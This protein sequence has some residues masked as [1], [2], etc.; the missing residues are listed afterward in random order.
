MEDDPAGPRGA[1]GGGVAGIVRKTSEV[2]NCSN[3]DDHSAQKLLTK[4]M[5]HQRR[6]RGPQARDP[7]GLPGRRQAA[8]H[9]ASD[10]QRRRQR[11]GQAEKGR[12]AGH[13]EGRVR[14]ARPRVREGALSTRHRPDRGLLPQGGR[15]A[16][17]GRGRRP[18]PSGFPPRAPRQVTHQRRAGARQP[19]AQA[20]QPRRAGAPRQEV[21]HQDDGRRALGDGRGLG[22]PPPVRRRHDR[23][24]VEG[25]KANEPAHAYESAAAEHAARIIA[26][27]VADNPIPGRKAA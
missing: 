16:V 25:A 26:P 7:G 11:A 4:H 22:G 13:P 27:V 12:R 20:P 8:L 1:R 3:P 14:R 2:P 6:P 21:A 19:R 5:R 9:R 17:R 18:G 23:R 24:A 15:G 10:A